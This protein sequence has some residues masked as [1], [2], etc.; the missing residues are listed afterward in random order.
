MIIKNADDKSH[1]IATLQSL[2]THPQATGETRKRIEQ[3]IRNR[4]AGMRGENE[5]AHEMKVHYGASRNWAILHDLRVV[6]D[7]LVAQIDHLVINRWLDMWVCESKH[8][9]EGVAINE[10]GE[11]SAFF[12]SKPYGVP[13][14]I[15]Q[16]AKHIR[17]LGRILDSG[18]VALPTRLGFT[19]KPELKSLVLVSKGARIS[20]PATKIAGIECVIKNDQFFSHVDKAVDDNSVLSTAKIISSETLERVAVQIAALH[21]PLRFDWH[22]RFGLDRNLPTPSA[23]APEAVLPLPV[24]TAPVRTTSSGPALQPQEHP[25]AGI[26]AATDSP[27]SGESSATTSNARPAKVTRRSS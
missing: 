2:L 24:A 8:F 13:S 23:P 22:A 15:E 12:G 7:D 18:A 4:Q 17:I 1:D 3:E 5:A 14:P 20:R 9:S 25:C 19:I 16:N 21:T 26:A 27:S 6:H 11:F 10:H